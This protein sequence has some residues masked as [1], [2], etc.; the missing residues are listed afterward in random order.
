M[1]ALYII[2]F[3]LL[4]GLIYLLTAPF[5]FEINTYQSIYRVR[6]HNWASARL[7]TT[8]ES[9]LMEIRIFWWKT[10]TDLFAAKPKPA[11]K[12]RKESPAKKRG[13]PQKKILAVL[14]SFKINRCYATIDTGDEALNG[15]L[16]P[17]AYGVSRLVHHPVVINFVDDNAVELE[18]ENNLFRILLAYVRS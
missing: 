11:T 5:Y 15:I 8:R 13:F 18:V 2:S 12:P 17:L 16:Y 6:F 14:K 9:L 1:V 3:L 7:Y 4:L 10:I